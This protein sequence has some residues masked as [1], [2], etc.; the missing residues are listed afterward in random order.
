MHSLL[1]GLP[2][3]GATVLL[4]GGKRTNAWGHYF[5]TAMS[6][7][8]FLVGLVSF[9]EMFG[10]PAEEREIVWTLSEWISVGSFQV[11]IAFQLDQLSIAFVLLIT[12]VGSLIHVYS[13]GYMEHDENRRKFFSYLNLFV[14]AMLVLVGSISFLAIAS[15]S[16]VSASLGMPRSMAASAYSR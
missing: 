2:M 10:M 7:G 16:T 4:L 12:G 8:S 1:I 3:L 11:P 5:A 15:F 13:I 6:I 9:N 14:S